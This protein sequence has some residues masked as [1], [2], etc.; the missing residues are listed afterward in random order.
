MLRHVIRAAAAT[1][2]IGTCAIPAQ[3]AP[4]GDL[5]GELKASAET[6]VQ[7]AAFRRCWYYHGARHCR[8]YES[9]YDDG[10]PY[11]GYEPYYYGPSIGFSFGGGHFGGGHFHGGHHR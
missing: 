8:W 3:A 6:G 5:T 7:Q 10:Y 4:I 1:A 11:Y 2:A 9:Y